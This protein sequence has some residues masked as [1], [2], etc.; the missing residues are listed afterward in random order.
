[1][2]LAGWVWCLLAA[3]LPLL[4]DPWSRYNYEPD[5]ALLLRACALALVGIVGANLVF[6]PG[7]AG[8]PRRGD[9]KVRPPVP[10][11]LA[12]VRIALL[13]LWSAYTLATITSI[14][15]FR[16]FWGEPRWGQGWLTFTA[17]LL[18]C[19]LAMR[20]LREAAVRSR[21]I[22]VV[23]LA[24]VPV[25]LYGLA[26]VAGLD[27]FFRDPSGRVHA[28]M[29]HANA[30]GGYLAIV[31]PL[32]CWRAL[33]AVGRRRLAWAALLALQLACLAATF[34][35]SSWLGALVGLGLLVVLPSPTSAVGTPALPSPAS[36]VGVPAL[37]SPASAVRERG[38]A[39]VGAR[40]AIGALGLAGAV[41]LV[42]L[43]LLPAPPPDAPLA[44]QTLT[45]LFRWSG[46]NAQVRL[47]AW[48]AT[49]EAVTARPWLGYGPE[50][51]D[52]A[53]PAFFPPSMALLGGL[54]AIAGRAHDE[55][56]ELGL[57]AGVPAALAY[58]AVVAL[59][60]RAGV[61]RWRQGDALAAGLL[62]ALAAA[63]VHHALDVGTAT[64]GTYWWLALGMLAAPGAPAAESTPPDKPDQRSDLRGG[65]I[66]P[67]ARTG[68]AILQIAVW[69][70]VA[71]AV[72]AFC[73][74]PLIADALG[75]HGMALASVG[76]NDAALVAL[77]E[78]AAL[79]PRPDSY[80]A[81]LAQVQV[82]RGDA[83]SA[84]ATLVRALGRTPSDL[85]LWTA[86]AR[87]RGARAERD[88]ALWPDAYAA[89]AGMLAASPRHPDVLMLCGDLYLTARDLPSAEYY[90][91]AA[92]D[93]APEYDQPYFNLATI[94]RMRGDT[95]AAE[96][97]TTAAQA[98]RAAWEAWVL[99]R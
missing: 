22:D 97:Y 51:L 90:Y 26:Q 6:A 36:A 1:M 77:E 69:L 20:T 72:A 73:L 25:C 75:A 84:D 33:K 38:R 12:G 86:L 27:P 44:W 42:A 10:A 94:A 99:Q 18:V 41:A 14:E 9:H 93:E 7:A 50:T 32:A 8:R 96:A 15:P 13:L 34:S 79:D 61:R 17:W 45:A 66:R 89:C 59:C 92:R 43:S 39:R 68:R 85:A 55:L 56:L 30:L 63:A 47:Y 80:A 60:V 3:G 21:V 31:V 82:A 24:S 95:A 40:L 48:Q 91:T 81:L 78:A 5:K 16:S 35:R 37:P 70:A 76:V 74:R 11:Q 52:L 87:L 67:P 98:K 4:V 71:G 23:L 46:P 54:P 19:V 2:K 64:T 58:L 62:A 83:I 28:T 65:A 29:A 57:W 49:A 53:L 88:P